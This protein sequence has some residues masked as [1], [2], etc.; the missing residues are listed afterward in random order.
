MAKKPSPTPTLSEEELATMEE[1][2]LQANSKVEAYLEKIR[3]E[4][5]T[6]RIKEQGDRRNKV[7]KRIE[8]EKWEATQ[9]KTYIPQRL[10]EI[11]REQASL[12]DRVSAF[13]DK[14]KDT[15][16]KEL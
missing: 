12:K 11:E 7:V 1:R 6:Q 16:I 5:E 14:I 2:R 10:E 15:E 9:K 4:R 3:A 13:N 8:A